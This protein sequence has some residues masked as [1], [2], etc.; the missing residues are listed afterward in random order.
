MRE[1][2]IEPP[3][4]NSISDEDSADEDEGGLIDNL[5][6]R[7]L[8]TNVEVVFSND[9]RIG[10]PEIQIP[11]DELSSELAAILDEDTLSGKTFFYLLVFDVVILI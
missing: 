3:D 2:F 5:S 10:D 11:F 7:Q 6:S 8:S 1:I 9:Q 4:P